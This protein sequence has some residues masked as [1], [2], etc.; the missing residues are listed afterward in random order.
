MIL[1]VENPNNSTKKT[2]LELRN[3]FINV[4]GYKVNSRKS[5]AFLYTDN[6][7]LEKKIKKTIPFT[8]ALKGVK[9]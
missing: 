2:L 1:Y 9:Y 8:I 5:G 4:T 3:E 7:Q 6:E